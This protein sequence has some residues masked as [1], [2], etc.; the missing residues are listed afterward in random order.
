MIFKIIPDLSFSLFFIA[1]CLSPFNLD[2]AIIVIMGII[3]LLNT[4]FIFKYVFSSSKFLR[5]FVIKQKAS[6][7]ENRYVASINNP[8]KENQ[9][10]VIFGTFA[11]YG[12]NEKVLLKEIDKDIFADMS[13]GLMSLSY[14]G[15]SL[16]TIGFIVGYF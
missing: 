16:G 9:E 3:I 2:L 5:G 10:S 15:V 4:I 6:F 7:D 13:F 12:K 8:V 1:L 11:T 14:V